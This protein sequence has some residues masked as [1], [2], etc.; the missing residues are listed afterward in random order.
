M[1]L[2]DHADRFRFLIHDRAGQFTVMFDAIF[3][4]AGIEVIE[5]HES[6]DAAGHHRYRGIEPL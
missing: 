4:A 5:P 3:A 2:G 1:D 6:H